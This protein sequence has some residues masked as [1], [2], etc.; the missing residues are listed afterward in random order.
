MI[1]RFCAYVLFAVLMDMAFCVGAGAEHTE[2]LQWMQGYKGA[3]GMSCCS[4]QDCRAATVALAGTDV[5]TKQQLVFVDGVLLSLPTAS[6][7][8]SET[9]TSYVCRQD[10]AVPL[11][12]ESVRCV[13]YV[14]GT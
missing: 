5:A 4:A 7:H 6:V 14:T 2:A 10:F 11:T 1:W 13:F 9:G 12:A 8:Q 3:S